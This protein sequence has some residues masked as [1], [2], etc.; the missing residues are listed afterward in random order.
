MTRNLQPTLIRGAFGVVFTLLAIGGAT[1]QALA[2]D[3]GVD[4]AERQC[5][6]V[7][8]APA[9]LSDAASPRAG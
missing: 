9:T 7:T 3:D 4:S 2:G 1:A 8:P 6:A 5:T